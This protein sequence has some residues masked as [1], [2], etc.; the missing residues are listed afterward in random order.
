MFLWI[1]RYWKINK[2][3]YFIS[4]NVFW[5]LCVFSKKNLNPNVFP[6]SY[7]CKYV[8][9]HLNMLKLFQQ[10]NMFFFYNVKL[11]S[12]KNF[13]FKYLKDLISTCLA[14]LMF[15]QPN[16]FQNFNELKNKG[17]CLNFPLDDN[18]ATFCTIWIQ[19]IYI[20]K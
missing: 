17:D 12:N 13:S 4:F 20:W 15:I 6:I 18:W 11:V 14:N 5:N 16:C 7:K 10:I 9:F 8:L 3:L 1:L 19:Y 2:S